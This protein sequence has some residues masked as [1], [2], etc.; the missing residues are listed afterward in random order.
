MTAAVNWNISW[1]ASLLYLIKIQSFLLHWS[2]SILELIIFRLVKSMFK[3]RSK[4]SQN[5]PNLDPNWIKNWPKSA[6]IVFAKFRIH[7]SRNNFRK[8]IFCISRNFAKLATLIISEMT[9]DEVKKTYD[10]D[11]QNKFCKKKLLK[12]IEM[13]WKW[14]KLI[15]NDW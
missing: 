11:L 4:M 6:V 9:L 14:T 8:N 12:I 5:G 10:D 1:R 13:F 3:C 2:N 7:F 15:R